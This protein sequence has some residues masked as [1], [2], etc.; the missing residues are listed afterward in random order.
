MA[1]LQQRDVEDWMYSAK[2][3]REVKL[4]C[5]STDRFGDFERPVLLVIELLAWPSGSDVSTDEK[6][7]VANL[8]L[9][10]FSFLVIVFGLDLLCLLDSGL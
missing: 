5:L 6:Y 9:L 7:L 10:W 2:G 3:R 1:L 8:K 4:V